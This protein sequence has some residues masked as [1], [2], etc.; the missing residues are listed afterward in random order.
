RKHALSFMRPFG[1]PVT[2]LNTID[3][4]G[5]QS[6]GNAGI[7]ACDDT[8]KASVETVRGKDYILL[9][10][11]TQDPPFFSSLMNS[12]NARFKTSGEEKKRDAEDPRNKDSE[13]PSTKSP[14]VNQERIA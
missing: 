9:P 6:N 2:I 11:W 14:R 1:C 12:P 8:G 13:I 5:N 3:H 7:K 4:L 10:L